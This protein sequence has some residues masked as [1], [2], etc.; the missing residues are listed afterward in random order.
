MNIDLWMVTYNPNFD[1][2]KT[3]KNI[4]IQ[5]WRHLGTIFQHSG[6]DIILIRQ[7][8]HILYF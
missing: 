8:Q 6:E 4:R 5:V 3:Y 1:S 2:L 7:L